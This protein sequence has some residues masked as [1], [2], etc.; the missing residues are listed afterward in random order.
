[1]TAPKDGNKRRIIVDLSFNS[2]QTQAVNTTVSKTH[3][4]GTPFSLKL[5]TVDSICQVLNVL[6][7]NV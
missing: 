2:G 4:V 1:M 3:Y 7:K 5:P 6:G